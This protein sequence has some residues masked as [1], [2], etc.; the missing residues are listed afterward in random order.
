VG[1]SST[2]LFLL[3]LVMALA[4]CCVAGRFLIKAA[5]ILNYFRVVR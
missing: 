4:R 5:G 2:P 3:R 1:E